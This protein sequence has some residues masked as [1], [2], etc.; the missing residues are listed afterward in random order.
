MG[1]TPLLK[2]FVIFLLKRKDCIPRPLVQR[3]RPITDQESLPKRKR[4]PIR[5]EASTEKNIAKKEGVT[6]YSPPKD[7][8]SRKFS[9]GS[10]FKDYGR[11]ARGNRGGTQNKTSWRQ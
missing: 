3:K 7:K 8:F 6:I 4:S 10:N 11:G 5:F 1:R 9:D 2:F